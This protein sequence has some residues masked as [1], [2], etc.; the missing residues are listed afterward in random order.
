MG[1]AGFQY[2]A[3]TAI[4]WYEFRADGIANW[5]VNGFTN[6]D[7]GKL[8]QRQMDALMTSRFYQKFGPPPNYKGPMPDLDVESKRKKK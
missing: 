5:L 6:D 2:A 7:Y 1:S 4:A 3:R 8:R